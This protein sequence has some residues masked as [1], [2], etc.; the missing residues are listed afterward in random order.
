MEK[1]NFTM[2]TFNTKAIAR[3]DTTSVEGAI[4]NL[5]LNGVLMES[6]EEIPLETDTEVELEIFL[7][8]IDIDFDAKVSLNLSAIVVRVEQKKMAVQFQMNKIDVDSLTHLRYIVAYNT[9]D[10]EAVIKQYYDYLDKRGEKSP[11]D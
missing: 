1:R 8:G 6:P 2:V 10:H 3:T 7:D 4:K 9:G 5:S 11:K